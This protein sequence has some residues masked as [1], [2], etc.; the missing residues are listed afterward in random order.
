MKKIFMLCLLGA[1][2]GYLAFLLQPVKWESRVL[3]RTGFV[4]SDLIVIPI[5]SPIEMAASLREKSFYKKIIEK[6]PQNLSKYFIDP[7]NKSK[8]EAIILSNVYENGLILISHKGN[9]EMQTSKELQIVMDSFF[10]NE[11]EILNR[12]KIDES[13]LIFNSIKSEISSQ[14]YLVIKFWWV[15]LLVGAILFPL[16]NFAFEIVLRNCRKIIKLD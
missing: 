12:T 5:I 1:I 16:C 13:A 6:S 2:L 14:Q 15:G 10:E 7:Y 11:K 3:I 8:F 9:H 4:K